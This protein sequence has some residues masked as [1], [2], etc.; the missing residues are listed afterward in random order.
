MVKMERLVEKLRSIYALT[1]RKHKLE[2]KRITTKNK[3]E[4]SR[5]IS[6]KQSICSAA[7]KAREPRIR[8]EWILRRGSIHEIKEPLP[9]IKFLLGAL[10]VNPK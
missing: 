1:M 10:H 3:L 8:P 5:S 7:A 4:M 6:S 9:A 2:E